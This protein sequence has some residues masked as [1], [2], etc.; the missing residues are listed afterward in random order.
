MRQNLWLSSVSLF[1]CLGLGAVAGC[2]APSNQTVDPREAAL[3]ACHMNDGT[4]DLNAELHAC[5]PGSVKKTTICHIP[6]GNP[7]NAH[8]ICVGNAAVPAHVNNHGDSIGAVQDRDAL[9]ASSAHRQRRRDRWRRGR[10]PGQ[11][12]GRRLGHHHR[13]VV[14]AILQR[15]S[16]SRR[17][18]MMRRI[19][20]RL[21]SL[22]SKRS[23]ECGAPG[24]LI[25]V[26]GRSRASAALTN[27]SSDA[28]SIGVWSLP[29][30]TT[31]SG[32]ARGRSSMGRPRAGTPM[33]NC[34]AAS[35]TSSM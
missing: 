12:L 34:C 30:R 7:A 33:P 17:N 10:W 24:W 29:A 28:F 2:D 18:A 23:N 26:S 21:A 8:T 35:G 5:D 3:A 32:S 31:S 19:V 14:G 16:R 1:A 22:S 13:P 4:V 9:S 27:A 15:S 11:W 6:P 25:S 20:A